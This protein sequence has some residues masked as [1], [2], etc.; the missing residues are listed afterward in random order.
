MESQYYI[1]ILTN[2]RNGTLYVGVTINLIKRIWEH[3][4][5]IVE[6]FSKKYDLHQLVYFEVT[7]GK[8]S[9]LQREKQLKRYHRK[10]KLDLI[11]EMNPNG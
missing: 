6:G 3:K 2:K 9:A 8:E 7:D 4:N 11:E 5:K 10:W 1:Y